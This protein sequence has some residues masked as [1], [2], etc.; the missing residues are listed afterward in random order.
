MMTFGVVSMQ[1]IPTMPRAWSA[2]PVEASVTRPMQHVVRRSFAVPSVASAPRTMLTFSFAEDQR[3]GSQVQVC[4]QC[5][6]G[7][8]GL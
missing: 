7:G 2:I 4:S 1:V 5:T 3:E 6:R 8:V